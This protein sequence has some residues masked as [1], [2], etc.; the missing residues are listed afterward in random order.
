MLLSLVLLQS[1]QV[2]DYG[3]V[4]GWVCVCVYIQYHTYISYYGVILF[5]LCYGI[6][7]HVYLM[8]KTPVTE[9][10]PFFSKTRHT[11]R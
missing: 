6:A 7:A 3:A 10:I 1:S 2:E 8:D 11:N 4:R 9:F 5:H